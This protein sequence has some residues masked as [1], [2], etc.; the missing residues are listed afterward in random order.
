MAAQEPQRPERLLE[1]T[2]QD[3]EK[4]PE[5]HRT[6]KRESEDATD[7][8]GEARDELDRPGENLHQAE[9]EGAE[10]GRGES[11]PD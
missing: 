2:E 1:Q 8:N 11:A 4:D 7:G 3:H 5:R 9:R 10:P 6:R